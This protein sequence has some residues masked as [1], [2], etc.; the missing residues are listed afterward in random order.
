MP[1]VEYTFTGE[2][3]HPLYYGVRRHIYYWPVKNLV[4]RKV[5]KAKITV[6]LRS[7][8]DLTTGYN[9]YLM[10]A[11]SKSWITTSSSEGKWK[12]Y[13]E[14]DN[15]MIQY[16]AKTESYFTKDNKTTFDSTPLYDDAVTLNLTARGDR[17]HTF[18]IN[19]PPE[20]QDI[21]LWN[22][23]SIYLAFYQVDGDYKKDEVIWGVESDHVGTIVLTVQ[24]SATV[25]YNNGTGWIPCIAKYWDGSDWIE[26]IPKY[27]NGSGWVECDSG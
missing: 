18:T 5:K 9:L 25:N 23:K 8:Y 16:E 10:N 2:K 4:G 17:K 14:S 21:S 19:I 7:T 27:Y 15:V 22:G 1:L 12:K 13:S 6:Y 24:Q 3:N 11:F 20:N 26:C